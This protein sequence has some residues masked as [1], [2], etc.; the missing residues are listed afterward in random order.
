M[1]RWLKRLGIAI[2]VIVAVV[3]AIVFFRASGVESPQQ[4]AQPVEFDVETDAEA[5]LD[6]LSAAIQLP[7]ISPTD[8]DA[9]TVPF[10]ELHELLEEKFPHF[11]EVA[12]RQFINELTLH[13]TLEGTKYGESHVVFL[14]HMDV[15]PVEAQTL[16]DWTHPPFSGV[17]SDGYIWGR[18]TLDN[19]HN[20]MAQLEAAEA[21]LER[22]ERPEHTLHFVFGHDEEIGGMQGAHVVAE[23]MQEDDLDVVTVYDEGLVVTDGIVP[24]ID[25]PVALVGITE[26]GYLTVEITASAEGGH[27]SMPPKELAVTRLADALNTLDEHPMDAVLD[28]PTR[29]M[30]ASISSEMDFAHRLIFRNLW[31]FEPLVLSQMTGSPS[32]NAAVRTTAAP[33]MLRASERENVLPQQAVAT[34]NFRINPRESIDDVLAYLDD[35]LEREYI[36]VAPVGEMRSEPSPIA[37]MEGP[38]YEALKRAFAT[39]HPGVAL[40]PNMLTGAADARHFTDLTAD[41]YRFTPVTLDAQDL[42]RIHGTDERI[43]VDDYLG[44]IDYYGALFRQW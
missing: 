44:L 33:T 21:W 23:Q 38:G 6:R 5:A 18:G 2:G 14:A 9:D 8:P 15:V 36:S 43:A 40:G 27:S 29:Q 17:E 41:V 31:L 13:Y 7:T 16:D 20:M 28:G 39:T 34:V 4:P 25:A 10:I 1:Y 32:T 11:H 24:G 26:R 3:L 12:E 22:G 37:R 35:L 30:F 42:E 19:K